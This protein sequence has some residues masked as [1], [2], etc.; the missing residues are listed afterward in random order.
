MTVVCVQRNTVCVQCVYT[1]NVY[2]TSVGCK[3][4]M[5]CLQQLPLSTKMLGYFGVA[6]T[7][8]HLQGYPGPSTQ[9][10]LRIAVYFT[11]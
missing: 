6:T 3:K 10:K 11:G 8:T 2:N 9:Q 1:H 4:K 5:L 7:S